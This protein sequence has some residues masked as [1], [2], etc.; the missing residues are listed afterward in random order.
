MSAIVV[1]TTTETI[2]EAKR[3]AH[4]LVEARLAA[5]VQIIGPITSIYRW[6]G[7]VE[8]AAEYLCVVK[9]RA[10]RYHQLEAAIREHHSYDVPEIIAVPVVEGSEPYLDWLDRCCTEESND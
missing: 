10:D 9:T 7:A 3:I 6:E 1:T 8:E 4:I 5:C 2:D